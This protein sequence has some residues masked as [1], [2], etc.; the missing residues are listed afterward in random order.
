MNGWPLRR[1]VASVSL[2][3]A[4]LLTPAAQGQGSFVLIAPANG[5]TVSPQSTQFN[6]TAYPGALSYSLLVGSTPGA[7]DALSFST[8][9][10]SNPSG[11]TSTTANLNPGA[12]FYT[13][14][15]VQTASGTASSTSTFQTKSMAYVT[16]P[17][18]G[19]TGI[20]QF[21]QLVWTPVPG[22]K[23][24]TLTV[25]P[26]AFNV[27]DNYMEVF[28][29]NVNSG[30]VWNLQP[31]TLYYVTLAT[32]TAAGWANS[33]STVTTG[34]NPPPTVRS[35]FYKTIFNLTAQIRQS[36]AF[37]GDLP[38]PGGYLYQDMLIHGYDPT[39]GS[40]C[41][42]MAQA[43]ADLL[44]THGIL[45]RV[46]NTTFEGADVH[47][48]NEYWDPFN[49]KWQI[50]DP[51][52][53]VMYFD[54][55]SGVGQ[56]VEDL[57]ALLLSG[58][59]AGIGPEWV[60]S[61]GSLYSTTYFMNPILY[62]NNPFPFGEL[63]EYQEVYDYVPNSPLPFLQE[64]DLSAPNPPSG[65][66]FI[67]FA[68]STDQA[69]LNIRGTD[70]T[71]SEL[72]ASGWAPSMWLW[73]PWSP[74][75]I[76]DGMKIYTA[77]WPSGFP[78][79]NTASLITPVYGARVAAHN[80]SFSW[81]PVPGAT[82]FEL[83][84][85][86]QPGAHDV[87]FYSTATAPNPGSVTSAVASVPSI[88][89]YY[90]TVLTQTASGWTNATTAFQATALTYLATP[91]NGAR[92]PP[93]KVQFN[94]TT[95][96]GAL[97]Y[98]LWVGT[99]PG[100]YDVLYY[101]TA[102]LAN[103]G[104]ITSTT[105]NLPAGVTLYAT[106]TTQT[107]TGS[108][109]STSV[110]QTA[111]PSYL[112]APANGATVSPLN[113]QFSWTS[114]SGALNYT[115]WIGTSPGTNDV[116]Y[117]TTANLANPAS[118]TSTTANLPDGE[119]L[120]ATLWTMTSSGYVSTPS[121]F[122]TSAAPYLSAPANGSTV[123]PLNTQ[124]SWT[125]VSGA[126]NY[127]LW[128][129]TAPGTQDVLY[130][131]TA[132]LATPG[133]VTS[134]TA[135]LPGGGTLYATLTTQT[136]SGKVKSTSSFQTS[137]TPYLSA[138]AN[139]STVSP[140]NTQL[141]WTAVPGA[142]NYTLWIGTAPGT[143]NVLYYTTANLATPGSVTSTTANLPGGGTLY[144]T[145]TTQTASGKV[146]STSSF[147][148][149]AAS[150]L[151]APASGSR[152]SP[153]NTQ[154]SWTAV[155]GALNYTLW[156]GTAPGTQNVFYYSTANLANAASVTSTT[157]NLPGGVTLYATV[158]TM[159]SSGYVSTP[160]S[161]QTS[162]TPYLSAP[163]SGSTVSPQNTQFS[164]TSVSGALNYTL[165]IGTS[166]G[167]QDVLFY[168]TALLANPA[169]VTS[170]TANLPGGVTL[171]AT[172]W[173]MTSSGYMSSASSFQTSAM[174]YLTA[175]ASGS[176]VSPL[177]TQFS[178]TAV[179]GALSYTLWVGTAPGTQDVLYYSTALLA[180]P[181]SVTSTTAN[182]PGGV[183]LYATMTTKTASG[184]VKSTSSFQTSATPYLSAPANGSTVSPLNTQ[185]SWTAVPGALNYTLW[186]GTAPGTQDVLYYST[187]LLANSA[188]VTSTSANLPGG[189]TLYATLW[190][191]TASGS[192]KST[193]SVQTS[194]TP[195]L[196][197]PANGS[198]LS[199]LN[200]QFSWTA[201][202]GALNYTLWIG[203]A[204]GT[205]DALYYTTALL[206]D[207]TS[208]TS[209]TANLPGGVTLYAT[210]TTQ[211]AS[212]KVRST[213][214][215]R[216][217]AKPTLTLP[218]NGATVSSRN[219]Q[220]SWT[221]APG[222]LSYELR[223]GTAPGTQN[224]LYYTTAHLA[225]PASV[226]STTANVPGANFP[227]GVTLYATLTTQTASGSVEST[228]S[229]QTSATSY[230]T[231]PA[232][233]ST[234]SPANTQFNW[235]AVPGVLSYTLWV[236]T[237]PGTYDALYYTT[238]HLADPAS[239]TSTTAN[240]PAGVTLYATMTTQTASGKVKSTSS[241][242]TS[243]TSY[244]TAPAG[245]STVSP[246][247][248]R[249]IW[250]AVP[251]VLSYTLWVGTSPGT[252]NVFYYTTAHLAD[253]TSV[254]STKANL[255][256]G[257]T[258]YATMTTQTASGKVKS[259][260][261]FQTSATTTL[262][263]PANGA[264]VTPRN[265]QFSWTTAPGALSYTLWVGTAPGTQDVLYYP[266]AHLVNPASV[267]STTANLPAGVT[268]YATLT[269]HTAS[270]N[271]KS[272]SSFQTPVISY[273]T[274]PVNG[275]NVFL[276]N[277]PFSWTTSP[278]ALNYTLWV[279]TTP[280]A[281]D[282]LFYTT[283]NTSNP[284][285]ITST[286]AT[287]APANTYYASLWT[288]SVSGYQETTSVFQTSA[289][290]VIT[291]PTNGA[292]NLDPAVP[293]TVSWTP[294]P[295][296]TSYELML[297]SSAGAKNYYD[298][299]A[300]T[301][302][303]TSVTLNPNTTY[304]ARLWTNASGT[305]THTD[306]TFATGYALAHLTYPLNGATGV[307]QFLPFTWSRPPGATGYILAVSLNSGFTNAFFWSGVGPSF[308]PTYTSQYVWPLGPDTTYYV[309]LCTLDPTPAPLGCVYTSFTAG[310]ALPPPSNQA[311]FYQSINSLTEQVS[312][313]GQG[314]S[315]HPI[316][317]TPL[318]QEMLSIGED[319]S[320]PAK[321]GDYDS[322]LL[323]LLS[324]NNI[325]GRLRNI[326]LD[327]ADGHD[328]V[329][330][331]D[332]FT[333]QWDVTDPFFGVSYFNSN[334]TAGQSAEQISGLL[335]AANYSGI[336]TDFITSYG[337]Q[338]MTSYY[339]DPMTD[340]NNV[341][342]FGMITSNDVL[343]T[344]PNSPLPFLDEV[345]LNDEGQTGFYAFNFQNQTDAVTIQN[346]SSSI[347]PVVTLTPANTQGWAA[348]VYLRSP[349]TI[350]SAVPSGMRIFTFRRV[351]F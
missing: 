11:T 248:T 211:T 187:A 289:T 72:S 51:T 295:T 166:P 293:I 136:A 296:A 100:T 126:L 118:V 61:S 343:S 308:I 175:P 168:T 16:S 150:F 12:T 68:N 46:R 165:W 244:L 245:G 60:T 221:T 199:P 210:L 102:L 242:Q 283:A 135:N 21:A 328:V 247:N 344:A 115:L 313:M 82:A 276:Q 163:A 214:S 170:T 326:S 274:S 141:S 24:Y 266:T 246:L 322:T 110:F 6:W 130:Y 7:S 191:Q 198:T 86:T 39:Q 267:T 333:Q 41:G 212:G 148:T 104:S 280:G 90:A 196:S 54:P 20:S 149:S 260:S 2:L 117:Y 219:V 182:L 234:V 180:N 227:G 58:N 265:V 350:S 268:L 31:N 282:A 96:P 286:T 19:A 169:S 307:S 155:L 42:N 25:S 259:T 55:A 204:P 253:P 35:S 121:S 147:Q 301:T 17:A 324:Q 194:A 142:V 269:T 217:T 186:I 161:F 277:I 325:L 44:T 300:V 225:H 318:Y 38:L 271:V 40:A 111:D 48:L 233:G 341:V 34:T 208:V 144:A 50:A 164:W 349:W 306:T 78:N 132:N 255:P 134:T 223:V 160:S 85:G 257:V 238:A 284:T 10:T 335:L 197:A 79:S 173:T 202:P 263:S 106:M 154:F 278:G 336:N 287:L 351:M 228:S 224:A 157:A 262:T 206:S 88:G 156:I 346:P 167:T 347:K 143:Q 241:F 297:G 230:L 314:L 250:M 5:T 310:A 236:G 4:T 177:N 243:A 128:I 84:I 28:A 331:W 320:R 181:A 114:G 129:G 49:A 119:T 81:T 66:Y 261:S 327:G 292:T 15:T 235:T 3:F 258:L 222:A 288:K 9:S 231:A 184:S 348:S 294:V 273:L 127:T 207:P 99:A 103:P 330:V 93:R 272:T 89:T 275:S 101:T 316:S 226:T 8:T 298:S 152:V 120:Y 229:F 131:S 240:L 171:Y 340:Y 159:T 138:P 178:W 57:N 64:V 319:P 145:L 75:S 32:Q 43:L 342:P 92:V 315:H 45:A 179:P 94:W 303:S 76:P 123:S 209:T 317:G 189:V 329:E 65:V 174:S 334:M 305:L 290:A 345:D 37:P 183:T 151:T 239:V 73:S 98:T 304:Y 71:V 70:V 33:Y 125:S 18:N 249:F 338:Y 281:K 29:G 108:A 218:A 80:I 285:G 195:Y 13:T 56:G 232:N 122:Q 162:A 109:A 188:S 23:S 256:G 190:T 309:K 107:A 63:D 192:V 213:S 252:Q 30:S 220:F 185:F 69:V 215:F 216:T 254:T 337:D 140:Q 312:A 116:F 27:R 158:W 87:Y 83:W 299:G 67:W 91:A 302:T 112:T 291:A 176:T 97:S 36:A 47:V 321:C 279:G 74:V 95:T 193:S 205:Y 22:A 52:F 113:T 251:G 1:A 200:T 133:S 77:P 53:G 237:T 201:V 264:T 339:M 139:G 203:T 270:G 172:L 14:L 105:A 332:P 59:L 153:L 62:F 323:D 124:F 26:T 137:A 311:Q 146:K